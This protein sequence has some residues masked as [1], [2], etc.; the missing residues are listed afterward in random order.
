M[1]KLTSLLLAL[2]CPIISFANEVYSIKGLVTDN[3]NRPMPG[4]HI[5]VSGTSLGVASAPDGSFLIDNL[6]S[7]TYTLNTS[8]AGYNTEYIT[9]QVPSEEPVLINLRPAVYNINQIVVTGTRN[10]KPLK[11]SPVLTQVLT[12]GSLEAADM[13]E[14]ATALEN[15]LPGI[16]FS[17]G[18]YGSNI[19]MFGLSGNYVLFLRDGNRLAGENNGNIDYGRLTLLGTDRIEIVRGASSVLYGSNAMAGVVNIISALRWIR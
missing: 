5:L 8:F 15:T 13:P 11:D 14:V 7:G 12:T 4:A 16:E 3:E 19:N 1:Y 17:Y 18:A 10:P 9:I 2:L 6:P